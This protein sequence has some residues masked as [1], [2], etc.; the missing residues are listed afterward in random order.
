MGDYML[1]EKY[2]ELINLDLDAGYNYLMKLS[3]QDR[4]QLLIKLNNNQ[5]YKLLGAYLKTLE[6]DNLK[7]ELAKVFHDDKNWLD[8]ISLGHLLN[9]EQ[10]K[11]QVVE[12][13]IDLGYAYDAVALAKTFEEDEWKEKTIEKIKKQNVVQQIELLKLVNDNN[14]KIN[15]IKDLIS[16]GAFNLSLTASVV[17]DNDDA[18]KEI[19]ALYKEKNL[20]QLYKNLAVTLTDDNNKLQVIDKLLKEDI[21]YAQEVALTLEKWPNKMYFLEKIAL[22]WHQADIFIDNLIDP[23]EYALA[24]KYIYY[25][26]ITKENYREYFKRVIKEK[27]KLLDRSDY[28]LIYEKLEPLMRECFVK[29]K[30]LKAENI[31]YMIKHFGYDVFKYIDSKNINQLLNIPINDLTKIYNLLNTESLN[32]DD[33][34]NIYN[35]LLQKEFTLQSRDIRNTFNRL[36]ILINESDQNSLNEELHQ[37]VERIDFIELLNNKVFQQQ[38]NIN[39]YSLKSEDNLL[40]FLQNLCLDIKINITS[41]KQNKY[42]LLNSIT[43]FYIQ[44]LRE[45]HVREGLLHKEE[46]LCLKQTPNK[47]K[48]IKKIFENSSVEQIKKVLAR[49]NC[50]NLNI[51]QI[52]LLN[53]DD[54]LNACLFFKKNP[55]NYNNSSISKAELAK[56][57]LNT[58]NTIL[59]EAYNQSLLNQLYYKNDILDSVLDNTNICYYDI[60]C[61]LNYQQI[62]A[63]LLDND[64]AFVNFKKLLDKYKIT[65]WNDTFNPILRK[66]EYDVTPGDIANLVNFS[67]VVLNRVNEVKNPVV[68]LNEINMLSSK[69]LIYK[70]IFKVDNYQYLSSNPNP[71]PS[72]MSREL[73]ITKSLDLYKKIYKRTSI[74]IP[75]LERVFKTK[76]DKEIK[77]TTGDIFNPINLTLGERTGSCMRVGGVGESLLNFCSIN[78]SGFHIRFEDNKSGE[79]LSRVSGFRNGNTVFLNELRDSLD[80]K[81]SNKDIINACEEYAKQLIIETKDSEKPIENVVVSNKYAMS[82]M[83]SRLVKLNVDDI[84]VGFDDFYTDINQN[85]IVLASTNN[86]ELVPIKLYSDMPLYDVRRQKTN[87][88]LSDYSAT[89]AVNKA[90]VLDAVLNDQSPTDCLFVDD[91]VISYIGEDWY[92]YIDSNYDIKSKIFSTISAERYKYA[93]KELNASY[94]IVKTFINSEK[95]LSEEGR[96]VK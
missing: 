65:C 12:M 70:N 44:T 16:H 62:K 59:T 27:L 37:I 90:I 30:D 38:L 32:E 58:F 69:G 88:Y 46:N 50:D 96:H 54:I 85:G 63:N 21:T 82:V 14:Y 86:K 4:Y 78:P 66:L 92:L 9:S 35:S 57:Y 42:D 49:L 93:I 81:F 3:N 45:E 33:V 87:V 91:A 41:D 17:L 19:M 76:T 7:L 61:N 13:L 48:Q 40:L 80:Q 84:K 23:N 34:N 11:Y 43:N 20:W 68:I 79:L 56:N 52:Q 36:K 5:K 24:I 1:E 15:F 64:E 60:L 51:K 31:D 47:D 67:D 39:G 94:E 74:T 72:S 73:R 18:K 2:Q 6:E 22:N 10:A 53:S 25:N 89:N 8:L 77:V 75:P 55:Q 71:N 95:H 26:A 28:A 83:T 29:G